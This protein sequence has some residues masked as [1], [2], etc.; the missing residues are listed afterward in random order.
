MGID[1]ASD[2]A[3]VRLLE[4]VTP[5]LD[6][7]DEDAVLPLLKPSAT[8]LGASDGLRD[9]IASHP[10]EGTVIAAG[11]ACSTAMEAGI[12][13][14]ILV[15]DLDGDIDAQIEAS[16]KGTV[17][18]ILAHGDN[19]DLVARYAPMFRGKVIL[20]TQ[21]RPRGNVLCFGGFTDGD[22]AVCLARHFGIGRIV[23]LGFDFDKPSDK[24]G[25]D[26][27]IKLR[28]LRWAREIIDPGSPD[29]VWPNH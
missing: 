18:L 29:I 3:S 2:E 11:S 25:S 4:A 15:T 19:T 13:P 24:P 9:D 28:K 6:L 12:L 21:G 5:N 17:T 7:D 16:S 14:D 23:L 27:E 20:T 26:P 10:P 8:V 1:P 22:R